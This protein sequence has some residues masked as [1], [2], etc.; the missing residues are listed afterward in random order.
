[1][2]SLSRPFEETPMHIKKIIPLDFESTKVVPES[3]V[4]QETDGF[5]SNCDILQFD[6]ENS[7]SSIPVIDLMAPNVVELIGHACE[8]WGTFHIINHGIPSSF[9]EDVESQARRL[10]ALPIEQKLKALRTAGG[11]AGYGA[12]RMSKFFTQ[13]LWHEG[14]TVVGSAVDHAKELWPHDHQAFCDVVENYQNKM[15]ELAGQILLLILK[16]LDVSEEDLSWKLPMS[17]DILQLNSFPA[18][19]HPESTF[20]LAPHTDSMLLTILHQSDKGLQIFRDGFGW[21]TVPP[22]PGAFVVNLGN[23]MDILSNGKFARVLHRVLVNQSKHRISV[24]YFYSP[25]IESQ[26]APLAK[27]KSPIYRSLTVKEFLQ[28]RAKHLE[29]AISVIRI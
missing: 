29:D 11:S 24:A 10:F 15:K 22:I 3:H 19:P 9:V 20:G 4:W 18:C 13:R 1:M 12:P 7:K 2:A 25:P 27:F 21:A 28:M 26:V 23:I 8:T 17:E 6:E 5:P 14:F 16:S